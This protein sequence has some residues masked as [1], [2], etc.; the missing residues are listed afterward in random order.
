MTTLSALC[1]PGS[2]VAKFALANLDFEYELA[3][4]VGYRRPPV[5]ESLMR[6]WRWVLR[7]LPE[8][9]EA[10]CLE[11]FRSTDSL[12]SWGVSPG[13]ATT[14][15]FPSLE[16]VTK[17]NDKRYSHQLEQQLGIALPHS[18]VVDSLDSLSGCVKSCPF[19]WVL[20][21]PLGFSAR[22]RV[23]G[24]VGVLSDSGLGW[25]RRKLAQGWTLLFEPWVDDRQD[26]SMHFDLHKDGTWR[27]RGACQLVG[28][29][30]GVYRGNRVL[31][32]WAPH[33]EELACATRVIEQLAN[34]G[35]WGPVGIDAFTGTLGGESI[36]RPLV[37]INARYSF[38]RLTLALGEWIPPGWSY[39]WWHPSF[40]DAHRVPTGLTPLAGQIHAGLYALPHCADPEQ[41]SG[42]VVAMAATSHE[43]AK[44]S[45]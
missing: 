11:D 29:A 45:D 30:G 24:K 26:F 43:L 31:P 17:A 37:E 25:A 8:A 38:G 42:T 35:Y 4:P 7:L 9:R 21:H 19:D 20:K 22:E 34:L 16:V 36:R 12:I 28:D 13:M 2:P 14:D 6:R 15:A 1:N 32:D 23:V 40:S 39:L 27:Y 41:A 3:S 18:Q 5:L 33:S 10:E 44:L